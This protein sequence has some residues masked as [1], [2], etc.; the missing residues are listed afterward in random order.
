MTCR[1]ALVRVVVAE[2]AHVH[3][4]RLV[5]GRDEPRRQRERLGHTRRV[6]RC[7]TRGR[8]RRARQAVGR[9]RGGVARAAEGVGEPV[10]RVDGEPDGALHPA[11]ERRRVG[12]RGREP[13][14]GGDQVVGGPGPR[15]RR[16]LQ[17]RWH[18]RS[19]WRTTGSRPTRATAPARS[20]WPRAGR[21][22][23]RCRR[24]SDRA[25]RSPSR[26]RACPSTSRRATRSATGS[27][28]DSRRPRRSRPCPPGSA[29][30]AST[31]AARARRRRRSR[32]R[33]ARASV[34]RSAR[35]AGSVIGTTVLRP[36]LPPPS[37][38]TTRVRCSC[39][40]SFGGVRTRRDVGGRRIVAVGPHGEPVPRGDGRGGRDA[41]ARDEAS[42][43]DPGLVG[44]VSVTSGD[45][46][47][48]R[49][50]HRR[51]TLPLHDAAG[52]VAHV[53]HA[54]AREQ[55]VDGPRRGWRRGDR[56]QQVE[57]VDEVARVPR[58]ARPSGT[59]RRWAAGTASSSSRGAR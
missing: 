5:V 2:P 22:A 20:R 16:R 6:P 29:R 57:G 50:P 10:A 43:G 51:I 9:Q 47:R 45:V 21:R 59:R 28:R 42:P 34:G 4:P 49:E 54:E 19:R 15:R 14:P 7:R 44:H 24:G 56:L 23:R 25:I 1:E 39:P 26:I 46:E 55:G 27:A 37:S 38:T 33:P 13:A 35:Y 31:A 40:P 8:G 30:P 36:S 53:E 3:D 18:R 11:H 12:R 41:D 48:E 58:V 17:A 32:S 52:V